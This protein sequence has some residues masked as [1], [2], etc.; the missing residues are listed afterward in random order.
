MGCSVPNHGTELNQ[1]PPPPT[2]VRD[3]RELSMEATICQ[4][5]PAILEEARE[6][7]PIPRIGV[8]LTTNRGRNIHMR[9]AHSI[10]Q[11]SFISGQSLSHGVRR[12]TP[13]VQSDAPMKRGHSD[14]CQ[15]RCTRQPDPSIASIGSSVTEFSANPIWIGGSAVTRTIAHP[16]PRSG[17]GPGP[18]QKPRR[19]EV[20]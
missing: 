2:S 6:T 7:V 17:F 11:I 9:S 4:V 14:H 19:A 12:R 16:R 1:S 10:P 8:E 13:T 20:R 5:A 18:L 15:C 3:G